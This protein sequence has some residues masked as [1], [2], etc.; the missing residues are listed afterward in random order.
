MITHVL[1]GCRLHFAVI[2]ATSIGGDSVMFGRMGPFLFKKNPIQDS[3]FKNGD[4]ML[5]L[6]IE[7]SITV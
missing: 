4:G 7:C 2:A 3:K 1:F 6:Q 5:Q